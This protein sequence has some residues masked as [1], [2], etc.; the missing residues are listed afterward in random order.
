MP[1]L[2]DEER[3][4]LVALLQV[5]PDGLGWSDIAQLVATAGSARAAWATLYPADLFGDP[6]PQREL[7]AAREAIADWSADLFTFVTFLEEDYPKRLRDVREMPPVIFA[8]GELRSAETAVS[9]VGSRSADHSAI[10]FADELA[11]R[12]VDQNITVLSGLA[13]GV[14]TAAHEAALRAGGRTVAVIGTGI[15]RQY[16]AQNRELHHRIADAGL[17]LSQFWPDSP[18][19]R[20]SFPLRNTTMS[21]YGYATVVIDATERSGTRIQAREAILHGRP[22][23]LSSRVVDSTAWGRKLVGQPGVYVASTPEQAMMTVDTILAVSSQIDELLALP[24]ADW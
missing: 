15:R 22:V 19:T 20:W 9:V 5:R 4:R 12:L 18:P 6:G 3:A 7:A 2:D 10:A 13:A 16:P 14:D 23:I 8:L 17:V 11:Q 21:A 1:A 24:G